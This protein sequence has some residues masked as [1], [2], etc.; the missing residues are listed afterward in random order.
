[1]TQAREK[2]EF[3]KVALSF[4]ELPMSAQDD[5]LGFVDRERI[6]ARAINLR[7]LE[8]IQA[9]RRIWDVAMVFVAEF[10]STA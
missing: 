1:M 4:A 5:F 6:D 2:T 7:N 10:E 3:I 9:F 8:R